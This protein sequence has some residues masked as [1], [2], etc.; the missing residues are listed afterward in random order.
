MNYVD[1]AVL[2]IIVLF[3][4][5]GFAKG[6]SKALISLAATVLSLA[7][8]FIFAKTL[9]NLIGGIGGLKEAL[10]T[11]IE[12]MFK[13]DIFNLTINLTEESSVAARLTELGLPEFIAL[14]LAPAIVKSVPEGMGGEMSIAKYLAPVIVNAI[15]VVVSF[16]LIFFTVRLIMKA[17]E[18]FIKSILMNKTLRTGDKILGALFG[19]VKAYFA[20]CIMLIL[21]ELL[22]PSV[23]AL[24]PAQE[25]LETSTLAK[26]IS[27]NNLIKQLFDELLGKYL[28]NLPIFR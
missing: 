25:M 3:V 19:V 16:L 21:L 26:T 23:S 28:K 1:I 22:I 8:A 12:G 20:L 4:I 24:Q 2:V 13:G 7:A 11:A 27:E 18:K 5:V 17:I 15:L 9:A 6:F 10:S 14:L